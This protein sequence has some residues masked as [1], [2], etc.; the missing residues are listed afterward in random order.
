MASVAVTLAGRRW[1]AGGKRRR[2]GSGGVLGRG[3]RCVGLDATDSHA[4]CP[5]GTL[6]EPCAV[7]RVPRGEGRV[8][9]RQASGGGDAKAMPPAPL[10]PLTSRA[11]TG[12]VLRAAPAFPPAP[13]AVAAAAAST[14]SRALLGLLERAA[15]YSAAGQ[16]RLPPFAPPSA[17]PYPSSAVLCAAWGCFISH[18]SLWCFNIYA[19]N[20]HCVTM[21]CPGEPVGLSGGA[22]SSERRR[23]R[24]TATA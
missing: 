3:G 6:W 9:H 11:G 1:D 12:P 13:A 5:R 10:P 7:G 2:G 21:T 8:G 22:A 19:A 4:S 17:A 20:E 14:R 15:I 16:P 18:F 24:L 23:H